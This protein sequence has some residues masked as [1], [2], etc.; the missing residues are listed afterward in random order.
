M[1]SEG[2]L[3]DILVHDNRIEQM[4]GS[5]IAAAYYID[6]NGL[7]KGKANIRG[8]TIIRLEISDN[9]IEDC[10]A[11]D[12]GDFPPEL[13]NQLAFGGIALQRI[14]DVRIRENLIGNNGT[15][16][17]DQICGIFASLA[18]GVDVEENT[19][20]ANGPLASANRVSFFGTRGGIVFPQL[21]DSDT[22]LVAA[23]TRSSRLTSIEFAARIHDNTV[24]TPLGP[25]LFLAAT[26][27]ISVVANHFTSYGFPA[28]RY[29]SRRERGKN[30]WRP[31]FQP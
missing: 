7:A 8:G 2:F 21:R 1:V 16:H 19:L 31:L 17:T 13:Q 23:E 3:Y 12:I 5:G 30:V 24:A 4:G 27:M 18:A 9:V 11:L 14:V 25:A 6:P 28:G 20:A 22:S 29:V 10:V 15:L 26:E